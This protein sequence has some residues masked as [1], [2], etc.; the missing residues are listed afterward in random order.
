M[1]TEGA[2]SDESVDE[3]APE[4]SISYQFEKVLPVFIFEDVLA[5]NCGD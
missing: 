5:D 1:L 3:D 2:E 4:E